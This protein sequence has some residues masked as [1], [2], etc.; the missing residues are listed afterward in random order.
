[1]TSYPGKIRCEAMPRLVRYSVCGAPPTRAAE[2]ILSR[3]DFSHSFQGRRGRSARVD[4]DMI[5]E[6]ILL[7]AHQCSAAKEQRLDQPG[8]KTQSGAKLTRAVVK[9]RIKGCWPGELTRSS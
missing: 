5:T 3:R 6:G 1:M 4:S 8:T 9:R 2:H 7:W